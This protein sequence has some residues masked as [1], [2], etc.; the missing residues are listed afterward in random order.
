MFDIGFAEIFLLSVIGLLVLG[1]ERLPA[2]ART[3]GGFV[4][5]A[6]LSYNNLKRTVEA[7]LAAADATAPLKEAQKE[8][9][10]VKRQV[11]E[12]TERL[13]E[14]QTRSPRALTPPEPRTAPPDEP[15]ADSHDAA[16][17]ERVRAAASAVTDGDPADPKANSS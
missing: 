3:L 15:A 13:D 6:R 10:S 7:E 16:V 4:R 11:S 1:P 12:L 2:V 5:K 14:D 8:L 17:E 9:E